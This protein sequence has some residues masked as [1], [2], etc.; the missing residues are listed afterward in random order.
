MAAP[1]PG[2]PG[3]L[4]PGSSQ[5]PFQAMIPVQTDG[6]IAGTG[7]NLGTTHITNGIFRLHPVEW[8]VGL[9]A[10]AAAAFSVQNSVSPRQ[11]A[12]SDNLL[13]KFQYSLVLDNRAG[14]LV[15][16]AD[17]HNEKLSPESQVIRQTADKALYRATQMLGVMG[18]ILGGPD[19]AFYPDEHL[20]PSDASDWI[21]ALVSYQSSQV[22]ATRSTPTNETK[23][24]GQ[25]TRGDFVAALTKTFCAQSKTPP[26]IK[27]PPVNTFGDVC[28]SSGYFP[29][30]ETAFARGWL[31]DDL[32][33][34]SDFDKNADCYSST[35]RFFWPSV[36]IRRGEAA[37]ILWA[38]A[39]N[40]IYSNFQ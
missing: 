4:S 24:Q 8:S 38:A 22:A 16:W 40:E 14:P 6:L 30:V 34:S 35:G 29:Y 2:N 3:V 20:A 19:L 11:I 21:N 1:C 37:K 12:T 25:I 32:K 15:W 23:A 5:I 10:G 39:L 33:A 27:K 7:K 13:R 31:V 9:A 28:L 26:C 36:T 18:V 17:R